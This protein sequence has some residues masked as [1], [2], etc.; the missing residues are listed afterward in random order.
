MSVLE[1]E[2]VTKLH[3]GSPPVAALRSVTL[4]ID[5][6]EFV[7]VVGPSGSGKSTLLPIVGTLERPTSGSVRVAGVAV[8]AMAD[9]ELSAIRAHAIGF[10]FQQFFLVPT[11]STLDNVA[12]GLLYRGASAAQRRKAA[13]RAL[14]AVG[15]AHRVEHRPSELSGGECQRAAIARALVGRP[16]VILADEPTGNVDSAQGA[17]ILGILSELNASGVTI[18]VVTHNREIADALTRVVA[19]RDGVVES[20]RYARP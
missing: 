11:L 6:G 17:E 14:Q 20:D 8:G 1:L 12:N 5:T 10:V 7:A 3:A 9:H 16:A 4:A 18:V 19:L 13:Q 15:L 2:D